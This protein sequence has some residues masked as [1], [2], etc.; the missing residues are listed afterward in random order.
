MRIYIPAK[1]VALLTFAGVIVHE[2]AH[3]FFCDLAKVPVYKVCYFR[4][5][6]P[7]GYVEHAPVKDIKSSF[8]ISVGP[9]IVNSILCAVLTF[10]AV[11]PTT[12]LSVED[13]SVVFS[14]LMWLGISIGTNAFNGGQAMVEFLSLVKENSVS[15]GLTLGVRLLILVI[16]A[17][18]WLDGVYVGLL[19]AI[20]VSAIL[21][22]ITIV[23]SK[24][25]L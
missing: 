7:S 18:N 19:Y 11:F 2:I 3:K 6:N 13:R 12:I 4:Y 17:I 1:L 23:I 20:G 22:A 5:D 15:R 16:K 25:F 14:I 9:F 8:L 24:W 21:P 10:P